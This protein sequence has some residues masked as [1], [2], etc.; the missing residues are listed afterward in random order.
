MTIELS[1]DLEE[2]LRAAAASQGLD[3]N[4]YATA[5]LRD[6][7]D[8]DLGFSDETE[9]APDLIAALQEGAADLKAGRLLTLEEAD[10]ELDAYLANRKTGSGQP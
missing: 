1:P 6:A 10:A 9:P 7:A 3:L 4:E 5:K 2:R 8:Q